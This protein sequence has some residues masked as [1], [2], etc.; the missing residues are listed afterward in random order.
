MSLTKLDSYDYDILPG[1]VSIK[2]DSTTDS[3]MVDILSELDKSNGR[4]YV[5]GCYYLFTGYE[6][7]SL[8]GA[9]YLDLKVTI[10]N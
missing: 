6:I 1:I 2:V 3:I 4:M 8:N 9:I 5:E 10:T 7:V